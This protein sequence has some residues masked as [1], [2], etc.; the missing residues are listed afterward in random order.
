MYN[1]HHFTH[2]C[3]KLL[4]L[5]EKE[6]EKSSKHAS[7]PLVLF[8]FS[9]NFN[10]FVFGVGT[11]SSIFKPPLPDSLSESVL[12]VHSWISDNEQLT[13]WWHKRTKNNWNDKIYGSNS[14]EGP[15]DEFRSNRPLMLSVSAF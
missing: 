1:Y 2:Y 12:V 13:I 7:L 5:I 6:M 10:N 4:L 15:D 9:D 3:Q 8:E 11:L 14:T